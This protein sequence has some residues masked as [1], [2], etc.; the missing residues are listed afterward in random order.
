MNKEKLERVVLVRI[1]KEDYKLLE[2]KSKKEDRNISAILREL[3]K[4]Y[5]SV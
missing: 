2:Q 5:T 4:L 3:I 1:T